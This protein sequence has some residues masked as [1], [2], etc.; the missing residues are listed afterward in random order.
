[1]ELRTFFGIAAAVTIGVVTAY[2]VVSQVTAWQISRALDA[3][4]AELQQ[5]SIEQ[6]Q[7]NQRTLDAQRAQNR[8]R[9]TDTAT[10]RD[11][12]RRCV[13]W[14]NAYETIGGD[15]AQVEMQRACR[16][17]SEYISTGR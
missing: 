8:A 6:R 14:S 3:S 9:R 15:Y 10:G 16:R 11:L 7:R 1:M 2:L 5:R 4:R 13:E 12:R 17:Y